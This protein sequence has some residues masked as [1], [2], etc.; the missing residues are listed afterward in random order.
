MSKS[1]TS[2]FHYKDREEL[3]LI[4][5]Q[6]NNIVGEMTLGESISDFW[7]RNLLPT[8]DSRAPL[9]STLLSHMSIKGLR[10]LRW[11]PIYSQWA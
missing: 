6:V 10:A 9:I 8:S 7:S 1:Y 3:S 5:M 4:S 11:V 2:P